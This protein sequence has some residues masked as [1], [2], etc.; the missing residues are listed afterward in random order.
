[1]VIAEIPEFE[2]LEQEAFGAS[3]V[4]SLRSVL[5]SQ[6]RGLEPELLSGTDAAHLVEVFSEI[7]RLGTAGKALVARRATECG[8]W[9]SSGY[10]SPTSWLA[11]KTK[12]AT[13]DA[14]GVLETADQVVV[15]PDV[16]NAF[17]SGSLSCSQ[18]QQIA[19]ASSVDPS[20]QADLLASAS[21]ESLRS[22]SKRCN[23]VVA[24]HVDERSAYNKARSARYFSGRF[25]E[26]GYR[27][28]G[29]LCPEDGAFLD[30]Q[31]RMRSDLQFRKARKSGRRESTGAYAAD[32]FMDLIRDGAGGSGSMSQT[33]GPRA[34]IKVTVDHAALMRE[35]TQGEEHCQIDGLGPVPVSVVKGILADS[36][37]QVLVTDSQDIIA[38][39]RQNRYVSARQRRALEARDQ[40]CVVPRCDETRRL[41]IDHIKEFAK[42]NPTK[43]DN[44]ALLCHH[45]HFLKTHRGWT[46]GGGPGAWKWSKPKSHA[47]P[48]A[49]VVA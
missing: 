42:G 44:L 19:H 22:L 5:G 13:Q 6:I 41:E 46:L 20:R 27:F 36:I 26:D 47:D 9:K 38:V 49:D 1:M 16:D 48:P 17:R 43:L 35:H 34:M 21:L 40:R 29:F 37:L 2:R 24:S 33:S 10:R 15:L 31:V 7:E 39:S 11:D 30:A 18:A 8:V 4:E 25:T 12:M 28:S 32:G 3:V 45:H 14:H 23:Q